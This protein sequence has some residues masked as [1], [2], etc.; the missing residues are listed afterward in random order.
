MDLGIILGN[1][2]LT[3]PERDHFDSILRQVEAAQRAGMN[4]IV[5]WTD[6]SIARRSSRTGCR[7]LRSTPASSL[8]PP[9][10]Q[11][12]SSSTAATEPKQPS[13]R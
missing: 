12:G 5:M 4:Y 3:V 11:G 6:G 13:R 7:C 1:V 10:R 9:A 2:P 8:S